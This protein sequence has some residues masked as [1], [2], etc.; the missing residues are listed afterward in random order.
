MKL[1]RR[2]MVAIAPAALVPPATVPAAQGPSPGAATPAE[3]LKAAQGRLRA[4]SE[5]LTKIAVPI[6]TEPAFQFRA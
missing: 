5:A 3:E 6:E 4:N 2:Q 1:T